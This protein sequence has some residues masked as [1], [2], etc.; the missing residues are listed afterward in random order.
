MERKTV[1][2]ES[3]N[4]S[5]AV[6]E[7]SFVW[8]VHM[9]LDLD[10]V[11]GAFDDDITAMAADQGVSCVPEAVRAVLRLIGVRPGPYELAAGSLGVNAVG[12]EY[13]RLAVELLGE[14]PLEKMRL[15]DPENVLVLAVY[16]DEEFSIID[17][18]RLLDPNPP[19]WDLRGD[20]DLKQRWSSVTEWFAAMSEEVIRIL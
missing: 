20:Y 8:T 5:S 10:R 14:L 3:A 11:A 9:G 2:I 7:N 12:T 4:E 16:E 15:T 19:V 13:K 6:I 17:G 1:A 18:S